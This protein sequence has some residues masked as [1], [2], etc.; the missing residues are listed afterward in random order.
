MSIERDEA[1]IRR[2]AM[3]YAMGADRRDKA[4]WAQVLTEDIV[5]AGPGFKAEGLA[6]NLSNLDFLGQL[7]TRTQHHVTNQLMT[8][9]GDVATGETYCIADHLTEKDGRREVLTWAIR[10]QDRLVRDGD[11]WRFKSRT[12]VVDWEETRVLS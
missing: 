6:A 3:L 1:A 2:A 5:I 10:Y 8:I 9:E 11:A 7:H 12:L 4:I